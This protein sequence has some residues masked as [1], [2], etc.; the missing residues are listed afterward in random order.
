MFNRDWNE[1]L[2]VITTETLGIE[3]GNAIL[4][5]GLYLG[6]RNGA[7]YPIILTGAVL[8]YTSKVMTGYSL[9]LRALPIVEKSRKAQ[10]IAEKLIQGECLEQEEEQYLLSKVDPD[11]DKL[12]C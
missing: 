7:V 4:N 10:Q 9:I 11:E 2:E 12:A 5:D 6:I 1:K 8:P 3:W